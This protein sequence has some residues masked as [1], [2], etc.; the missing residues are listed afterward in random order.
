MF[1]GRFHCLIA[2]LVSSTYLTTLPLCAGDFPPPGKRGPD[3]SSITKLDDSAAVRKAMAQLQSNDPAVR[4]EAA[5]S[6]A[7][8]STGTAETRAGFSDLPVDAPKKERMPLDRDVIDRIAKV[9]I[10]AIDRGD[11]LAMT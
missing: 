9:L 5:E 4:I 8:Y 2:L 6:L 10:P 1:N 7:D 11:E 3:R